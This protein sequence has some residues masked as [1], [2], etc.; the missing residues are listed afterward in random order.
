[1]PDIPGRWLNNGS[2]P[3]SKLTPN[4][5]I[6][7]TQ[8]A[9]GS[10]IL[11]ADGSVVLSQ[12][13][14]FNNFRGINV[15]TPTNAN[16]AANKAYVDNQI[17]ALYSIFDD[18]GSARAATTGNINLASPGATH[19]GV[20]L[21]NGDRLFVRAQTN[22]AE[23]G[24]YVFSGA[25][26]AL[27]RDLSMNVWSEFPGATFAI[28]EGSVYADTIWYTTVNAN[29]TL[30]TTPV[31]FVQVN[32]QGLVIGNFN[33]E[34]PSGTINGSNTAFTLSKTP[35]SNLILLFHSGVL[36]LPG[37]DF[38][39]SGATCNLSGSVPQSGEWLRAFYIS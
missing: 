32:A 36:L 34:T 24:L 27:V 4:A 21:A 7:L 5:G 13:F 31:T 10:I 9:Q 28:E 29:G 2:V 14:N 17:A 23:N 30:G 33:I 20:T 39:L 16:D 11:L 3:G 25:T 12:N 38:T 6:L 22:A 15:A 8:L 26:S 35:A 1:M 19:D 37:V 18:K